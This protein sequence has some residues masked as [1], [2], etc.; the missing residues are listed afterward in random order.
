MQSFEVGLFIDNDALSMPEDNLDLDRS[1]KIP[2]GHDRAIHG[3]QYSGQ[4]IVNEGAT[5]LTTKDAHLIQSKPFTY[6][7]LLPYAYAKP[8]ESQVRS[9]EHKRVMIKGSSK[10]KGHI[11]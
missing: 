4:R 6:Q 9:V 8:P 3:H 2:K 10:K 5:L 11:Y 7:D 1:F